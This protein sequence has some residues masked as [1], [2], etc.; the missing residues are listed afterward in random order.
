MARSV[1]RL[2]LAL[3]VDEAVR[4]AAAA[5][6]TAVRRAIDEKAA[7]LRFARLDALHVTL[8]FLGD[9]PAPL[10]DRL[11]DVLRPPLA[12][13]AFEASLDRL[14]T[15]P[16]RG[17]PRVVWAGLADGRDQASAIYD[18]LRPRLEA[19]G[20]APA[21][22]PH[23]YTPHL[24]LARLKPTADRGRSLQRVLSAVPPPHARWR[25]DHVAL[26][27]SDLS[28]NRARYTVKVTTALA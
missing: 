16:P 27:E 7:G 24:T 17:S 22:E 10:V 21:F 12:I 4:D 26:Y 23:G 28:A 11:Q 25:I 3:D 15:F 5:W 6:M 14:G 9:V 8:H 1:M 18:A 19:A 20:A 2:F 13:P